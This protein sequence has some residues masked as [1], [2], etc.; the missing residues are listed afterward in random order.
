MITETPLSGFDNK[1]SYTKLNYP[2][3][4]CKKC[5]SMYWNMLSIAAR[6]S[7]KTYSICKLIKHW[8]KNSIMKDGE[9]YDV[10]TIL[11]S[12]TV[13]ANEIYKSLKS[14]DFEKDVYEE[15]SD[16][17]LLAIIDDVKQRKEEVEE[18]HEYVKYY[19]IFAK[20]PEEKLEALYDKNPKMF[21]VLEKHDFAHYK[22]I[23]HRKPEVVICVLD[24]LMGTGSFS[25]K[26]KSALT[27]AF[28]KNRHIGICFA[29]LTQ[30]LKAIP[31]SIRINSSI[32][33]LG[34]FQN[35]KIVLEDIYEEISNVLKLEE[36]DELYTYA[37]DKPYGTLVLDLTNGKRF[38][39]GFD[40]ELSMDK[41][42]NIDNK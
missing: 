8:E 17:T 29:L 32:F 2:Q 33:L 36:F 16:S 19:K 25:T 7:G 24:D 28:I 18:Y 9:E 10:R 3:C 41:N 6:Q 42:K 34:K 37:T 12:P 11:I 31:K 39:C 38:L 30:S 35:K 13:Q 40:T 20:T 1:L 14:L 27:N 21:E 4:S 23:P 26:S 15:Y 22:D 5:P